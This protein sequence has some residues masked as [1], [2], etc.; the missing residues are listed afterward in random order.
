MRQHVAGHAYGIRNTVRRSVMASNQTP[1]APMHDDRKAHRRGNLDVPQVLE[2]NR[3]HAAQQ[4][5]AEIQ[6]PLGRRVH[7]DGNL[8]VVHIGDQPKRVEHIQGTRLHR[9]VGSGKA[10]MQEGL[11]RGFALLRDDLAAVV[12]M[13]AVG[14]DAVEAGET[15]DRGDGFG[16]KLGDV[17]PAAQLTHAAVG[18][19]GECAQIDHRRRSSL[20]FDDD[21]SVV[22]VE[23]RVEHRIRRGEFH[24]QGTALAF[25]GHVAHRCRDGI[26]QRLVVA[27]FA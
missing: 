17:F 24:V 26:P 10:A 19:Q 22:A 9:N 14:H 25:F 27:H 16:E 20:Q 21:P 11:E 7:V 18:Q 8:L 1:E 12:L 4:R 23:H 5:M 15:A 3:R 13:K 2:M 6:W